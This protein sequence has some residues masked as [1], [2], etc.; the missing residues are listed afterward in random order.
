M[1]CGLDGHR[2][3]S[4][5]RMPTISSQDGADASRRKPAWRGQDAASPIEPKTRS[6]LTVQMTV[7]FGVRELGM[8][9]KQ[10]L[11]TISERFRFQYRLPDPCAPLCAAVQKSL[12]IQQPRGFFLPAAGARAREAEA[13]LDGTTIPRAGEP[14]SAS[15][16]HALTPRAARAWLC[17]GLGVAPRSRAVWPSG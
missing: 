15:S 7:F 14:S 16:W 13:L 9:K 3:R 6:L 1:R 17:R 4:G 11:R 12:G 2:G 8:F 5:K 10:L